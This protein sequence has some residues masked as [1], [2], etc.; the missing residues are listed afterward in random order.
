MQKK[1]LINYL[2]HIVSFEFISLNTLKKANILYQFQIFILTVQLFY[3][4]K[5]VLP[6]LCL[7]KSYLS[8]YAKCDVTLPYNL[9]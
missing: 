4:Y 7:Y 5:G 6:I 8:L 3:L 1:R 2:K 9:F